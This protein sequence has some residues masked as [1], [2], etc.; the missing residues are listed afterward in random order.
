[1]TDLINAAPG[2]ERGGSGGRP[3]GGGGEPPGVPN[4]PL[5]GRGFYTLGFGGGGWCSTGHNLYAGARDA[6]TQHVA[7]ASWSFF[8]RVWS[9]DPAVS[10]WRRCPPWFFDLGNLQ[11]SGDPAPRY[12][13]AGSTSRELSQTGLFQRAR[14]LEQADRL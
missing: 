14:D 6:R 12:F 5:F 13:R 8:A 4:R 11:F 2:G 7:V 3:P 1:M 9:H 10:V